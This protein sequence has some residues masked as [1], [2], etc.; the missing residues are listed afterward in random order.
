VSQ[1]INVLPIIA[2]HVLTL[3]NYAT[4]R[5]S[6]LDIVVFF[7]FPLSVAALAGWRH[8]K[9]HAIAV[10]ALVSSFSL[11]A[12]ILLTL[13]VMVFSFIQSTETTGADPYLSQ[14][15]KLLREINANISCT[16]L[17]SIAIVAISIVA[18][19]FM[20]TDADVVENHTMVVLVAGFITFTLNIIMIVKRMYLL[21]ENA[22]LAKSVGRFRFR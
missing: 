15:R 5:M 3:R 18:L 7:G 4:G 6:L 22:S 9:L 16:V 19:A 14:R 10:N 8:F 17:I 13:L 21:M 20:E 12:T 2:E 1:K 11:F